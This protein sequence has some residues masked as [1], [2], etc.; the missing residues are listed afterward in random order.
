MT[1]TC[2]P[3]LG[4]SQHAGLATEIGSRLMLALAAHDIEVFAPA[5]QLLIGEKLDICGRLIFEGGRQRLCWRHCLGPIPCCGM[6]RQV[7]QL[8]RAGARVPENQKNIEGFMVWCWCHITNHLKPTSSWAPRLPPIL[9][10]PQVVVALDVLE[11][12]NQEARWRRVL[13]EV[14]PV[15]MPLLSSPHAT[16][17]CVFKPAARIVHVGRTTDI[18]AVDGGLSRMS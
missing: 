17:R 8:H 11:L 16:W 12:L 7:R 5:D 18:G 15:M 4:R 3:A 10:R 1:S 9:V 2:V 6:V 14:D 13:A